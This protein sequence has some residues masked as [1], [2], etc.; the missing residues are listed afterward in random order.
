[1]FP[2]F[3]YKADVLIR[4][5]RYWGAVKVVDLSDEDT[6]NVFGVICYIAREIVTHLR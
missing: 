1:V 6:G 4:N 3:V 5:N 2:E